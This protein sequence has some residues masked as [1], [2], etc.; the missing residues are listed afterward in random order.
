MSSTTQAIDTQS[1]GHGLT[2]TSELSLASILVRLARCRSVVC[3]MVW[4]PDGQEQHGALFNGSR[5]R[6]ASD[7]AVAR[8]S[9]RQMPHLCGLTRTSGHRL[10]ALGPLL[11]PVGSREP[12]RK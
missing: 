4:G 2:V 7:R 6:R 5:H 9:A 12:A 11:P 3:L 10:A 8:C 1:H